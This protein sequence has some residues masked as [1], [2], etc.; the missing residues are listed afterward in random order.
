MH[1]T[2]VNGKFVKKD[3]KGLEMS[4]AHAGQLRRKIQKALAQTRW[5]ETYRVAA[6]LGIGCSLEGYHVYEEH[7][8]PRCK[9]ILCWNCCANPNTAKGKYPYDCMLCPVCGC[10]ILIQDYNRRDK[11]IKD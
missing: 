2:Y 5:T 6:L 10:S 11:S 7:Q 8:C 3:E 4:E 9:A 1:L